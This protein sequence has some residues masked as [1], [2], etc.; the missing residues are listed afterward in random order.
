MKSSHIIIAVLALVVAILL[1]LIIRTRKRQAAEE[2][3]K[4]VTNNLL[5]TV[6]TTTIV[7]PSQGNEIVISPS[8]VNSIDQG[9]GTEMMR[10]NISSV[11]AD[12]ENRMGTQPAEF[13]IKTYSSSGQLMGAT[14]VKN[15]FTTT[16]VS[17]YSAQQAV[18]NGTINH[19][20]SNGET[21]GGSGY[22]NTPQGETLFGMFCS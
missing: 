17:G 16:G 21:L 9:A 4:D 6:S 19:G 22:Y 8:G 18:V 5:A 20:Y 10:Q 2:D 14:T 13:T 7:D 3:A 11:M 1:V 12:I 15:P